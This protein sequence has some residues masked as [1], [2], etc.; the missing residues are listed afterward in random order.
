MKNIIMTIAFLFFGMSIFAQMPRY[1]DIRVNFT[2]PEIGH[3][4]QSPI[5]LSYQFKV[6]NQGPDTLYGDDSLLFRPTHTFNQTTL[7]MR[8]RG[9][10][11]IV[12][13]G[14]SFFVDDTIFINGDID[15]D[16]MKLFFSYTPACF[17]R[18]PTRRLDS[19]FIEDQKDN[20]D[21]L[22]LVHRAA[23]A[24]VLSKLTNRIKVFPNPTSSADLNLDWPENGNFTV[25]I[26]DVNGRE[27]FSAVMPLIAG[28]NKIPLNGL[29]S[30][31][32]FLT[33]QNE[34][35]QWNA[36]IMISTD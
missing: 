28:T 27:H 2:K 23:K 6:T 30:G 33:I 11:K 5:Y 18:N 10:D 22:F 34:N 25:S 20:S 24:G 15:M 35:T 31:L 32:Y 9:I 3:L 1:C 14:D 8:V 17:S 29:G 26:S 13:P 16:Q 4:V 7:D 12:V 36:K 21:R 19:E